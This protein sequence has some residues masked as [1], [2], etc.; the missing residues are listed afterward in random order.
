MKTRTTIRKDLIID[1][2]EDDELNF[3]EYGTHPYTATIIAREIEGRRIDEFGPQATA[4]TVQSV[5]RTLRGMV[6]EGLLV[7]VRD[8]QEVWNAIA[9]NGVDM[10]VTGYYSTRT[11]E[12]DKQRAQ[13]WKD[14]SAE[15]SEKALDRMMATFSKAHEIPA[16]PALPS[17]S[18]VVDMG[19]AE[20]IDPDDGYVPF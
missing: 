20:I 16:L 18:R 15:R 8:R 7:A 19:A 2:L 10:P 4:Q 17:P 1:F 6:K 5:A 14:G 13:A 12:R 3:Q 9:K 11:M